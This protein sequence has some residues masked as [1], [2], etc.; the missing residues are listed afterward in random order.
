VAAVGGVE[1]SEVEEGLHEL[2]RK[3]LVRP[4]RSS[5]VEGEDEFSFWH[6]L[7]RDVAY[8]QIPRA[9]RS[10]K[11][12]AAAAW[13]EA[14]AGDRAADH[15][16]LLAE[17][18]RRALEFA[19]A[20]G[21]DERIEELQA[22]ASQFLTLAGDRAFNLDVRKAERYYA[23]ALRVAPQGTGQYAQLLLKHAQAAFSRPG[24]EGI[25]LGRRAVEAFR[26]LNDNRGTAGAMAHLS[27]TLWN[28]GQTTES[29]A[30]LIEAL[31]LVEDDPSP[32]LAAVYSGLAGQAMTAGRARES[33]A[34]SEKG[35][36]LAERFGL[37]PLKA[38]LVQFI[39]SARVH[40]EDVGGLDDLR[41]AL[42]IGLEAGIAHETALAY[43]NLAGSLSDSEGPEAGLELYEE[44]IEFAKRRGLIG[45]A[46]WA[47]GETSWC[48]FDLGRWDD[49]IALA[50]DYADGVGQVATIVRTQ[51]A[52][53]LVLRGA[54]T[55]ARVE[56]AEILPRA[57]EIGDAQIVAP[58]LVVAAELEIQGRRH[59]AA[60]A[61]LS[62]LE[63]TISDKPLF[64]YATLP[65]VSRVCLAAEDAARL[66]RMLADQPQPCYPRPRTARLAADAVLAELEGRVEEASQLHA[67]AAAAWGEMG[68]VVEQALSLLGR[69]R[70]LVQLGRPEA[71]RDLDEAR[72][73]FSQRQARPLE[74]EAERLIGAAA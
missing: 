11:H 29:T 14:L 16:E 37:T 21:S 41:T 72:R 50:A 12:R 20:A 71:A 53:V 30:V 39:G 10:A 74:A 28:L 58:T 2:V 68:C 15:A 67:E 8:G 61:L 9:S 18:Y 7:V 51:N 27:R 13:L 31:A 49:L 5:S 22:K 56:L 26:E 1:S 62:E 6:L 66:A 33:L 19:Q 55:E 73:I 60:L 35:L 48:L 32:E 59:D 52:H 57:R 42:S 23:D 44:G 40:L 25:D 34:W 4:A 38:R 17:H 70:S 36:P 65:E 3:E 69:G 63:E 47:R 46:N 43:T 64:R 45:H 54:L 24:I